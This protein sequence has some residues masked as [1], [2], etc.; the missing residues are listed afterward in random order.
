MIIRD[1]VH[2]AVYARALVLRAADVDD[3]ACS[4]LARRPY[5]AVCRRFTAR[6]R[7]IVATNLRVRIATEGS[8]SEDRP[9][10]NPDSTGASSV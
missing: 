4:P 1:E 3:I 10:Y 5:D 8:E 7:R 6:E 2:H 9:K